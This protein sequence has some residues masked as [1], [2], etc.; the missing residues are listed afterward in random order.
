METP[1]VQNQRQPSFIER[2]Q[3]RKK[4]NK[5]PKKKRKTK[6]KGPQIIAHRMDV[7]AKD[8]RRVAERKEKKGRKG[9]SRGG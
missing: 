7:S 1:I 6:Y 3:R 2:K 8:C 9:W 5:Q 4:R